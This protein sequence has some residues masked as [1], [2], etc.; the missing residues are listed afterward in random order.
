MNT[1]I[2]KQTKKANQLSEISTS[3]KRLV[4]ADKVYINTKLEKFSIPVNNEIKLEGNK[5]QLLFLYDRSRLV[6]NMQVVG[7]ARDKR[8]KAN[9]ELRELTGEEINKMLNKL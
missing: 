3:N 5:I 1:V 2:E 7:N 9:H 8:Y 6:F 4:E